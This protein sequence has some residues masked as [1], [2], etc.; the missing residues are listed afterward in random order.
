[1]IE[2]QLNKYIDK[3]ARELY[4]T[5]IRTKELNWKALIHTYMNYAITIGYEYKDTEPNFVKVIDHDV[6]YQQ[7]LENKMSIKEMASFHDV[8]YYCIVNRIE[9]LITNKQ[10]MQ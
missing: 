5:L 7:I 4:N 1:M 3:L 2:H 10:T 8:S 6:L 9:Y